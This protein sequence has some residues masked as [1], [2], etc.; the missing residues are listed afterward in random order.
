MVYARDTFLFGISGI[1]ILILNIWIN[2]RLDRDW[3]RVWTNSCVQIQ[4][5]LNL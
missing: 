4:E 5:Y 2:K 1:F 3:Y